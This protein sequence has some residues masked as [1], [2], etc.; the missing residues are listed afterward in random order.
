[1]KYNNSN[2][3]TGIAA[4]ILSAGYSSRMKRFKPLLHVGETTAVQKLVRSVKDAGIGRIVTVT[5]YSRELLRPVLDSEGCIEAYNA[6]YDSGMFSSIKTGMSKARELYPDAAGYLVMP[7]DCPLISA[8]TVRTVAEHAGH[9]SGGED[10]FVPVFEGKKGHPLFVPKF[11]AEEICSYDGPGGLKAVTDKYWDRMVRIPVSDEGCL[12]DMDTQES[13]SEL[14]EFYRS[15]C[16]RK[17]LQELACGRHIALVRHGETMQHA[18]KMFIGQYDVPLNEKGRMQIVQ[19]AEQLAADFACPRVIYASDLSRAMESAEIILRKFSEKNN[20]EYTA[21]YTAGREALMY[22]ESAKTD[23]CDAQNTAA[24]AGAV[25]IMRVPG[26]REID[27]G[28]WDGQPVSRIK[29]EF[30]EEY[31]RRGEDM[32]IF[33]TGNK[34]ENFYD[35]QYRAVKTLRKILENDDSKEIIIVANSGVIRALQNNLEGKR[36]N[37]EWTPVPKGGF[38]VIGQCSRKTT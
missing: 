33:K 13:Y 25:K 34:S 12:L 15:G 5:G 1:M 26:F 3:N 35:M 11:Y 4:V 30:P 20:E 27:L 37:D 38:V 36:V 29:A 17:D 21:E 2:N 16:V 7:V 22:H 10:F 28:K 24:Q 19:S 31:M 18:E 32:F 9:D 6:D 14:L 8:E 23:V